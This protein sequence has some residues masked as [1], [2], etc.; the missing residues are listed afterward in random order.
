M[1]HI[2]RKVFK[3]QILT[4]EEAREAMDSMM[5]GRASPEEIAGFLGALAARGESS[6]EIVG[7]VEAM[8]ARA[9]PFVTQRLDLIDVCGTGG[10]HLDTFNISTTNALLLASLGL[11]VVKHGNRAVSSQSGSAD[12]LEKLG[13]PISGDTL[14]RDFDAK[15]FVFLFAPDF[16]PAMKHVAAIRRALGVRTLFNVLGPLA[17]PAPVK[18]QV[19]GVFE[20]RLVALMAN[21]LKELGVEDALVV[22]GEDGLDEVSL[23]QSTLAARV[24]KDQIELFSLTPEDF[25]VARAP[26]EALRGGLSSDNARI[27]ESVLKGEQGPRRD[28]VLINAGAALVVCGMAEDWRAG[29]RLAAEAIDSGKA[30]AKLQELQ[31]IQV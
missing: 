9:L 30:R 27:T 6:Q 23:S 28:V 24:R 25:G 19:I 1:K 10:D 31:G 5:E 16:H 22:C 11:G 4:R 21:A 15:G 12:V 7:C 29:A 2:L 20:P 13:I 14:Q 17:N 3:G 26:V 8:R 18:R